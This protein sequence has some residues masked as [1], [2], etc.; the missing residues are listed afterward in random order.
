MISRPMACDLLVEDIENKHTTENG[1]MFII[2]VDKGSKNEEW[3]TSF[4]MSQ[5]TYAECLAMID[6]AKAM[7]LNEMGYGYGDEADE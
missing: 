6:T 3:N 7:L 4:R 1:P 2:M 5:T